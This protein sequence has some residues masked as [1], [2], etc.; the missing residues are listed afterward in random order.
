VPPPKVTDDTKPSRTLDL[1]L[2][3]GGGALVAL[4]GVGFFVA[5]ATIADA[6]DSLATNCVPKYFDGSTCGQARAGRQP[7]AQADADTMVTWQGLRIASV[8]S[9]GVG[10]AS[11]AW[12]TVRLVSTDKSSARSTWSLAVGPRIGGGFVAL[13]GAF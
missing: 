7:D 8:V 12:G 5:N 3:I 13:E 2:V 1:G 11:I 6:R 9:V 10:L 4:G